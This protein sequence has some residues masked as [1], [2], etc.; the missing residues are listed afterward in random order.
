MAMTEHGNEAATSAHEGL[1]SK[2]TAMFKTGMAAFATLLIGQAHAA[3]VTVLHQHRAIFLDGGIG[4]QEWSHWQAKTKGLDGVWRVRLKSPGGKLAG[5]I[6]GEDIRRR[7]FTTYVIGTDEC[8]SACAL[9][10]LAG[11]KRYIATTARLGF[12]A[13][14]RMEGKEGQ[15]SPR[16]SG[17]G[18]IV[19]AYITNLGYPYDTV[20]C[21]TEQ[22]PS[23]PIKPFDLKRDVERCKIDVVVIEP[24]P[25]ATAPP[26]YRPQVPAYTPPPPRYPPLL[27]YACVAS[28]GLNFRSGPGTGYPPVMQ[29]PQNTCLFVEVNNCI[30]V[31]DGEWWCQSILQFSTGLGWINIRFM[32]FT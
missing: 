17:K 2:E 27:K 1:Y 28:E 22:D 15:G 5:L 8:F 9:I 32:R 13:A 19:G 26:T 11:D 30:Q 3:N 24:N 12:H 25:K 18:A 29:A 6:I 7:K 16:E 10:W 21:A 4:L 14:F 23:Q 31:H 20:I